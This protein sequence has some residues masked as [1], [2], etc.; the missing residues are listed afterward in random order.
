MSAGGGRADLAIVVLARENL[1]KALLQQNRW[2][3][4]LDEFRAILAVS[5]H[6]LVA[7]RGAAEASFG[8]GDWDEAIVHYR[9]YLG[10][11]NDPEALH[12]L[13][14]ALASS[15]RLDEAIMALR[16][17]VALDSGHGP[18]AR[19][20]ARAL[21][22]PPRSDEALQHAQRA[23]GIQPQDAGSRYVLAHVAERPRPNRRG[24]ERMAARAAARFR[25]DAG[26]RGLTRESARPVRL[27]R[28]VEFEP[29]QSTI[30]Q[31]G[32]DKE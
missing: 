31:E 23:V 3:E 22:A 25:G 18:A 11:R 17:V 30:R 5:P 8:Q 15:G 16:D 19:N 9:A 12:Q 21:S 13:G 29:S 7:H 28:N 27:C 2:Q 14:V 10:G 26:T 24:P 20:L 6:H 4:A 32:G 1:G